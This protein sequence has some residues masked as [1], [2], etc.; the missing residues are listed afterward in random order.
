MDQMLLF[1]LF[2][3]TMLVAWRGHRILALWL[4]GLTLV[5]SIADYLHHATDALPLSF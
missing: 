5:L 1:G 3:A 2:A 4:F